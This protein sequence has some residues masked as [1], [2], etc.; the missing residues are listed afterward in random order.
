[1]GNFFREKGF[2]F[3]DT[4]VGVALLVIVF[5][6]I[7]GAYQLGLK[8]VGQGQRK[9]AATAIAQGEIEQ[10][11]N[12]PYQLIGVSGSFPNG[13][14]A[15]T[16]RKVLNNVE[17]TIG[18]RV[19]F[20]VDD[21]DGIALPEDDCPND[22]KKVEVDVSWPGVLA[23]GV[24]LTT[25]IAPKNLVQECG[26]GGGVLGISVFDAYGV[27]VSLPLI[28]IK[29]P[30]TNQTLKTAEPLTGQ[31]YFSL[32][33]SSYKVMVSKQGYSQERTYG[34]DEIAIP[35]KP[36]PIVLE[37][38]LI[39]QSFSIDKLS[40]FF[41]RT[42]SPWG[43]KD[44]SDSFLDESKISEKFNVVI[45]QGKVE[46]ATTSD[47]YFESGYLFSTDIAPVNLVSWDKFNFSDL[48]PALTESRYQIYYATSTGWFL[49]PEQDLPGNTTGFALSPVDLSALAAS[50]YPKLKIKANLTTLSANLTPVLED[51]QLSWITNVATAIPNATFALKGAKIIGKDAEENP[52]YKYSQNHITNVNGQINIPNLEWDSWTFSIPP[53]TGLDLVELKPSPQ[54]IALW[55]GTTVNVD[56]YLDSENSFLLTV[57]DK[58]TAQPIFAA[59]SRLSNSGLAYDV[60]QYT[61]EDGQT[62]FIPLEEASYTLEVRAPG[63]L[64]KMMTVAVSGDMT[65]TVQLEQIE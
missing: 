23:G 39:E 13:I 40:S 10:I 17:Y 16:T 30:A 8:A 33:T 35:E 32:A 15:S 31:H 4:L 51:W 41:V 65:E 58:G 1:M 9:I 64:P 11:R 54:P 22:Y 2:T 56:L 21:A 24:L 14:L 27:F 7:F 38:E 55:P 45:N 62:Y 18:R 3:I 47:G 26:S 63:Y 49:V 37:D 48:K 29:D 28:E 57:Q 19:D 6:G 34:I 50:L 25:D 42:F 5:L 52:V 36:H 12:L 59:S 60:T 46:L 53:A 44:F 43:R 61:N 20:V